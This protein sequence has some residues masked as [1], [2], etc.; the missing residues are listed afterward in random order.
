MN[1]PLLVKGLYRTYGNPAP[2]CAVNLLLPTGENVVAAAYSLEG[3]SQKPLSLKQANSLFGHEHVGVLYDSTDIRTYPVLEVDLGNISGETGKPLLLDEVFEGTTRGK[4]LLARVVEDVPQPRRFEVSVS[5]HDVQKQACYRDV[6]AS[7]HYRL[8]QKIERDRELTSAE[9]RAMQRCWPYVEVYLPKETRKVAGMNVSCKSLKRMA[10]DKYAA[11]PS[12]VLFYSIQNEV[13]A[14]RSMWEFFFPTFQPS[15]LLG[16][17]SAHHLEILGKGAFMD[18]A[19]AFP[20]EHVIEVRFPLHKGF[21][22]TEFLIAQIR[23]ADS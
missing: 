14:Q 20:F 23:R 7:Q 17:L 8:F 2:E 9:I 15:Y 18:L 21:E 10:R 19:T 4:N 22:K 11:Y 16:K 5:S 1:Y 6:E 13:Y 3:G 12:K